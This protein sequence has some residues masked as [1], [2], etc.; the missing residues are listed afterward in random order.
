MH[1]KLEVNRF[2]AAHGN[3][4]YAEHFACDTFDLMWQKLLFET[5]ISHRKNILFLPND[6]NI[7]L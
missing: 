3:P 2:S 1:N 7:A 6:I 5:F 4:G